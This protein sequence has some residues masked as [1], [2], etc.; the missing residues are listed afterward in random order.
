MRAQVWQTDNSNFEP[1]FVFVFSLC[2]QIFCML[3]L[4]N[5]N[6]IDYDESLRV[7]HQMSL[8]TLTVSF[9]LTRIFSFHSH[10]V[11]KCTCCCPVH[12]STICTI[13]S[14]IRAHLHCLFFDVELIRHRKHW[15][16]TNLA[17]ATSFTA[18]IRRFLFLFLFLFI[19]YFS[20]C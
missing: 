8:L 5:G 14:T 1:W 17:D 12:V 16:G 11:D 7:K 6:V 3:V 15:F 13:Y 20:T 4:K 19:K 9:R 10:T 18:T 2:D